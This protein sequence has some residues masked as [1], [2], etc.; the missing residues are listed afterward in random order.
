MQAAVVTPRKN[1]VDYRNIRLRIET[2]NRL[3][4]L[5][6]Q[7]TQQSRLRLTFDDALNLFINDLEKQREYYAQV[8]AKRE[9]MLLEEDESRE[10]MAKKLAELEKN[11]KKVTDALRSQ[12]HKID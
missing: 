7:Y 12:G 10:L 8:A 5:M 1:D 6:L 11:V 3:E 9:E 2:Y 4:K